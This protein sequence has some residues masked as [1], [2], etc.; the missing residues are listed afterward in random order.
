MCPAGKY[1]AARRPFVKKGRMELFAKWHGSRQTRAL[2]L[3][4]GRRIFLD[5]TQIAFRDR[6]HS[7]RGPGARPTDRRSAVRAQNLQG[8]SGYRPIHRSA[9]ERLRNHHISPRRNPFVRWPRRSPR[10]AASRLRSRSRWFRLFRRWFASDSAFLHAASAFDVP[11]IAM[12]GPTDGK[13]FTRHHRN[14]T[15]ISAN[16]S[17]AC[18]PC[19]RNEDLPAGSPGSSGQVLV[20]AL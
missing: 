18:A 9:P 19:W 1:E 8:S 14:A 20:S 4:L 3:R 15:V 16:K 2:P 11:V 10:P 7:R 13:L 12:F 5:A 17:F 6:L